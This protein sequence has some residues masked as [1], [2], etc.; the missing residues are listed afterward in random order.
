MNQIPSSAK[1]VLKKVQK[2]FRYKEEKQEEWKS[3]A[4][5]V[6]AGQYFYD[7]CDGFALTCAELLSRE[8]KE[9][10][11]IIICKAQGIG[12]LVCGLTINGDTWILDNNKPYVYHWKEPRDYEW[13]YFMKLSEPGVWR[14]VDENTS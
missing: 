1:S 3:H 13:L 4:E 9:G 2:Y 12:H 11:S 6:D 14:K 10:V 7:D 5:E 8:E